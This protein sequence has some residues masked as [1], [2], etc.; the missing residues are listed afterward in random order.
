MENM[1]KWL[2]RTVVPSFLASGCV[3]CVTMLYFVLSIGL[4]A[5]FI[6]VPT[7]SVAGESLSLP[8]LD[9]RLSDTQGWDVLHELGNPRDPLEE[10]SREMFNF[11]IE[12]KLVPPAG[13]IAPSEQLAEPPGQ[14]PDA[15][16]GHTAPAPSGGRKNLQWQWE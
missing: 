14:Q 13:G 1:K 10:T 9:D 8:P 4:S 6:M 5:G 3:T 7:D 12:Q 2:S 11:S 15:P 16:R